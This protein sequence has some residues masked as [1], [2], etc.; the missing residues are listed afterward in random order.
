MC[1]S[2]YAVC[3]TVCV[4]GRSYICGA[5]SCLNVVHDE[6]ATRVFGCQ[7]KDMHVI[8]TRSGRPV[9]PRKFYGD[10]VSG[11]TTDGEVEGKEEH[12]T[13]ENDDDDMDD[14]DNGDD[15][16]DDDETSDDDIVVMGA[17]S[18]KPGITHSTAN[19]MS[20]GSIQTHA[21]KMDVG[22][23]TNHNMIYKVR[24]TNTYLAAGVGDVSYHLVIVYI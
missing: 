14:V 20:P 19:Q 6:E 9:L 18:K 12:D 16:D 11:S 22:V 24:G 8:T 21:Q 4:L 5:V 17:V 1:T 23:Q 10:M 13:L 2:G 3:F 7:E 15:N